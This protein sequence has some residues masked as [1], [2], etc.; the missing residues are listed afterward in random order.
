MTKQEPSAKWY[1]P[2]ENTEIQANRA[3]KTKE[4]RYLGK[5]QK[6]DITPYF[7]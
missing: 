1:E 2:S 7:L 6:F 3:A 4:K 5:S